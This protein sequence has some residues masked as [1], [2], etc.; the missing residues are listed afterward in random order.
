MVARD[1]PCRADCQCADGWSSRGALAAAVSRAGALGMV[2]I[3]SAGCALVLDEQLGH[4]RELGRPFG[5]GLVAWVI[6]SEP[7][8]LTAAI[9]RQTGAAVGQFRRGLFVGPARAVDAGIDVVIA[10]GAE[11]GGHGEP[12]VGTLPLLA[13]ILDHL[14]V[15]VLAAGGVSSGRATAAVLAAG[16]SGA[17]LGTAFCA[18]TE[19]L[20]SDRACRALLSA[21]D[22]DTVSAP[23]SSTSPRAIHGR[24]RSQNGCCAGGRGNRL[25]GRG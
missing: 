12:T 6:A 16:A 5:I 2:G 11:G 25:Q 22:T 20:L 23:A 1:G 10:R 13:A 9:A 17:W 3:G 14:S 7:Q 15:P 18:C 8:L 4:L 21:Q 24:R 19:T